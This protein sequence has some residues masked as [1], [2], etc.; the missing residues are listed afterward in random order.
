MRPRRAKTDACRIF[1]FQS[2]CNKARDFERKTRFK[3]YEDRAKK[4]KIELEETKAR[5]TE[6][7]LH[8]DVDDHE[9]WCPYDFGEYRLMTI[10][11]R[12][13]AELGLW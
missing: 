8:G 1:G 12:N 10:D 13:A 4:K 3:Q 7:I 6:M 5:R 2:L 9:S 11:E